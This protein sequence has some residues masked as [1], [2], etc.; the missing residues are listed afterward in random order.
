MGEVEGRIAYVTCELVSLS[1]MTLEGSRR[2]EFHS[3][4]LTTQILGEVLM[5]V[6]LVF[7]DLLIALK[8]TSTFRAFELVMFHPMTLELVPVTEVSTTDFAFVRPG[9]WS[10]CG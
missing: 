10:W 5:I 8:Y 6:H 4:L 2:S 7:L 9:G 1:Q 3:T